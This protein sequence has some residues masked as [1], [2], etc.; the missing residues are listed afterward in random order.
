MYICTIRDG[1]VYNRIVHV[2]MFILAFAATGPA[3]LEAAWP[4]FGDGPNGF[5][6]D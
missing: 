6:S 2:R 4:Q 5:Y 3:R 1:G